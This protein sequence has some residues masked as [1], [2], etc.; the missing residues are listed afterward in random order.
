MKKRSVSLK[1]HRTSVTL[2]AEFWAALDDIA[3]RE[4]TSL[5]KLIE[6]VDGARGTDNLS[7]ALRVYILKSMKGAPAA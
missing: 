1:G 7:S 3:A 5:Q 2:E 4:K 6:N